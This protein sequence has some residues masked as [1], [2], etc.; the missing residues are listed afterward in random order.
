L[1]PLVVATE[2]DAALTLEALDPV[3]TA[4]TKCWIRILPREVSTSD[5]SQIPL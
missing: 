5:A 2:L 1:F 4:E 3:G